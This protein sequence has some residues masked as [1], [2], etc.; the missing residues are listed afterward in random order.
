M[1]ASQYY[2]AVSKNRLW[3]KDLRECRKADVVFPTH[4]LADANHKCVNLAHRSSFKSF[5]K[6]TQ[7]L[8]FKTFIVK[9]IWFLINQKF[10]KI[11]QMAQT[12]QCFRKI[13][14]STF[15]LHQESECAVNF[16][17]ER[18]H[19]C[20]AYNSEEQLSSHLV[21]SSWRRPGSNLIAVSAFLEEGSWGA[22]M[23]SSL[24][25]PAID[26]KGMKCTCVRGSSY[27]GRKRSSLIWWSVTETGSPGKCSQH[28]AW[29]NWK[30]CWT[31]LLVIWFSFRQSWEEQGVGLSDP[32]GSLPIWAILWF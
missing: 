4:E 30:S 21:C 15:W 20:C 13:Y 18:L 16:S 6:C 25:W 7:I 24:W 19:L 10:H 12:N 29:Q 26:P 31:M 8:T 9:K 27:D 32:Y 11:I 23:V 5:K 22:G 14:I 17:R 2:T 3:S 28:Q 1:E